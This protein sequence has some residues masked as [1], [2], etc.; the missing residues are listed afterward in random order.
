[1]S[2]AIC[3]RDLCFQAPG[4]ASVGGD[5]PTGNAAAPTNAG[6][7]AAPSGACPIAAA[8]PRAAVVFAAQ[9]LALAISCLCAAP[10]TAQQPAAQQSGWEFTLSPYAW[11]AGIDGQLRTPLRREPD[12]DFS[13]DFGDVVSNLRTVPIMGMAEVRYGRFGLVADLMN[14]SLE[15]DVTTR[16]VLYSGGK[17]RVTTTGVG[18]IGLF[19]V[20]DLPRGSLDLGGGIRPWWVSTRVSLDSA[21]AESRSFKQSTNWVDPVISV[22][23]H[24]RLTEQLGV[25]AYADIGG[26]GAGS[27]LTWQALGVLD[28]HAN[29]WLSLHAG[30]RYL[31]FDFKDRRTSLDTS[32]SGP[33][34]G[35]TIRF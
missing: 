5:I 12:I 7:R 22:R 3:H 30:W 33:I 24:L 8:P 1:M 16:D 13:A 25:T 19:R 31:A 20:V 14:L 29:E 17:A 34:I 4:A 32:L 9:C 21:L 27:E 6:L 26:F 15:Q 2:E 23:A 35:A 10:A 11:F 18:L 28:W